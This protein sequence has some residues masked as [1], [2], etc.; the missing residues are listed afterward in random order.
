MFDVTDRSSFEACPLWTQK[1]KKLA[2]NSS[3]PGILIGNKT[4]LISLRDVTETE[5]RQFAEEIGIKYCELSIKEARN[6]LEPFNIL[7]R[8][9]YKLY[10]TTAG[11]FREML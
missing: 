4:D 11:Q 10:Q 1:L 8:D 5:A 2:K 9:F 3:V 7:A 6:V